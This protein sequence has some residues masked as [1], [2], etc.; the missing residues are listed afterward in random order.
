M[1]E[2]GYYYGVLVLIYR[3]S[4]GVYISEA[5]K[6][7]NSANSHDPNVLKIHGSCTLPETHLKNQWL[8][9]EHVLFGK[10]SAPFQVLFVCSLLNFKFR[11]QPLIRLEWKETLGCW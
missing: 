3:G 1:G 10:V 8:E 7:A 4:M 11:G 9:D 2:G 5:T 6:A